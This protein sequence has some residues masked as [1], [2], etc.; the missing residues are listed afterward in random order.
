MWKHSGSDTAY[1]WPH[2]YSVIKK[3][4]PPR[5]F[6]KFFPNGWEFLINF[7]TH[8][9]C[10]HLYT[11]LQIF[12]QVSQTL[13]KLCHTKRDHLANFYISLE[14][15]LLSLLTEHMTSL[16]TSCHI[17]HVCWHYKNV[18]FIVTCYRQRST[19]LS[20]TYANVW[21]CAF[22]TF[23]AYYVNWVV[24]LNMA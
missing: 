24:A 22:W 11:R 3:K 12:I 10:Y 18:Y 20:M 16:L 1:Q 15:L 13:T 5:V 23:C 9:L 2:M 6:W 7:F 17:P 19:N 8:L 4:S 14:L 21:T